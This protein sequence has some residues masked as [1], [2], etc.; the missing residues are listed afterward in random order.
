MFNSKIPLLAGSTANV[1]EV[2]LSG[3]TNAIRQAGGNIKFTTE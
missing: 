3:L 2:N 1:Y